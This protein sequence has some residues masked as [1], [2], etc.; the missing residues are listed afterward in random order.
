MRNFLISINNLVSE[1]LSHEDVSNEYV[2]N[3]NKLSNLGNVVFIYAESL[4]RTFRS[5]NGVNYIPNI[6]KISSQGLDFSNIMQI[7]GMGWTMAGI[8]NTQCSIPLAMMQA[9]TGSNLS[10]FLSGANCIVSIPALVPRTF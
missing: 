9:N 7:P 8:V 10:S 3:D 1:Q 5:I 4:E 2:V 6:T